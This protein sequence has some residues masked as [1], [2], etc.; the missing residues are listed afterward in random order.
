[1]SRLYFN[2]LIALLLIT[3]VMGC[4]NKSNKLTEATA[5]KAENSIVNP[6]QQ[7]LPIIMVI[8]SDNLLER[9]GALKSQSANGRNYVLRDYQK[10]LLA[11]DDNPT[12]VSTIQDK[13]IKRDFPLTD[14]E[15]Q[16][17][18]L[19]TQETTDMAD[20]IDKD[21]KTIL[22]TTTSPD[23]ILELDYSDKLDMAS[24]NVKERQIGYT[25]RAIDAYTNKVI[26]TISGNNITGEQL[27]Q[28]I[29]EELE[30]KI[31]GFSDEI[32]NY[33]SDILS[34]GREVTVRVNIQQGSNI[35][36]TDTNVEKETYADWIVNYIKTNTVKGT[37]KLQRNTNDE[38]YFVN[39]RIPI[40]NN[41]GTQ[42]GVYDWTKDFC[43]SLNSKLGVKA[44]N[45]AQGLGEV[46]VTI[47]KL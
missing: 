22:L 20:G 36:L 42:Y 21:T 6:I 18:Q 24:H 1:M 26:S 3:C 47:E 12:I 35:H 2:Y 40:I 33:F 37:Y 30:D 44:L 23:I 7:A 15:Q 27:A 5:D 39:V 38:L 14:F 13:F 9:F 29:N 25:L 17:K 34:R 10:Y 46:L 8:P 16:L 41:D 32:Q 31:D 43:N 19:S 28:T 11:N 4:N 45:K